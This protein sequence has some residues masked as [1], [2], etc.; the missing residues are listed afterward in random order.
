MIGTIVKCFFVGVYGVV[1]NL[2]VIGL[3]VAV[4]LAGLAA[5]LSLMY[6][7]AVLVS[8]TFSLQVCFSKSK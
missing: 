3:S 4:S 5:V 2:L 1:D 6:A 8:L 7:P